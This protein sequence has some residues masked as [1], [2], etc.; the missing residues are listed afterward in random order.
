[1]RI[2]DTAY[3]IRTVYPVG[4]AVAALIAAESDVERQAGLQRDDAG[5]CQLPSVALRSLL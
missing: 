5:G 2:G 4:Y 1:M 3:H